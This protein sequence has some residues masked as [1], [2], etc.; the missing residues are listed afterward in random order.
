MRTIHIGRFTNF[1]A[2][3]IAAMLRD[4]PSGQIPINLE[5][6]H[7]LI[8]RLKVRP[9]LVAKSL[10]INAP[11]GVRNLYALACDEILGIEM[12][13]AV[14][15]AIKGLHESVDQHLLRVPSSPSSGASEWQLIA[16]QRFADLVVE[17]G[18]LLENPGDG[19]PDHWIWYWTAMA[20]AEVAIARSNC[21]AT[22]VMSHGELELLVDHYCDCMGDYRRFADNYPMD[23]GPVANIV[24]AVVGIDE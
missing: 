8:G 24:A 7:Y 10:T 11:S 4:H 1:P 17:A 15:A 22:S 13:P 20:F 21:H 3:A 2:T 23:D 5:T 19:L 6:V 12:V 16:N 14:A 18:K 9:G